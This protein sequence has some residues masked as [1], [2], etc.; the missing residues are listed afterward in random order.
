MRRALE[1]TENTGMAVFYDHGPSLHPHDKNVAGQRLALWA[2]AKD[3]GYTDLVH[4]GPLLESVLYENGNAILSF[5]H[6]GG[7]ITASRR[8][9]GPGLF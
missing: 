2:L 7:G 5:K 9:E 3:Y 6:V 4:S 8:R 1:T